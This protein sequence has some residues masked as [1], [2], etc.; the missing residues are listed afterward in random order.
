MQREEDDRRTTGDVDNDDEFAE[1]RRPWAVPENGDLPAREISKRSPRSPRPV[2][3]RAPRTDSPRDDRR[4]RQP[5]ALGF[6]AELLVGIVERIAASPRAMA[7]MLAAAWQEAERRAAEDKPWADLEKALGECRDRV[8]ASG[9]VDQLRMFDT[10]AS[11]ADEAR[12]M[13]RYPLLDTALTREQHFVV[14]ASAFAHNDAIAEHMRIDLDALRKRQERL[15]K[16]EQDLFAKWRAELD[17]LCLA[18]I[19][20]ERAGA[21]LDELHDDSDNYER[22]VMELMHARL[23][24]DA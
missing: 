4:Y 18:E 24:A 15:R 19:V 16:H 12:G 7:S 14:L 17:L 11:R 10:W 8:A 23:V 6:G 2:L 3:A 1:R 20:L 5:T 9:N 21:D 13:R 22:A